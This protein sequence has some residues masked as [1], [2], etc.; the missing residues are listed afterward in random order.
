MSNIANNFFT[1]IKPSIEEWVMIISF[2]VVMLF[3]LNFQISMLVAFSVFAVYIFSNLFL[4]DKKFRKKMI[5]IGNWLFLLLLLMFIADTISTYYMVLIEKVAYEGNPIVVWLWKT[6]G[7]NIGEIIRITIALIMFSFTFYQLHSSNIKASFVAFIML[8]A[9]IL[10][11]ALVLDNN[12]TLLYQY[13][14]G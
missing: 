2:I 1:S 4:K 10:A 6:F 12:L 5:K 3:T 7:V 8:I 9:M 14:C 13:S 11:W